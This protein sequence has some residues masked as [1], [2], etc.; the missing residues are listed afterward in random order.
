LQPNSQVA[1]DVRGRLITDLNT[2]QIVPSRNGASQIV[3]YLT[4]ERYGLG[5]SLDKINL[6]S[7]KAAANYALSNQLFSDGATDPNATFKE[8]LTQLAGAFNGM[9]FESFGQVYCKIDGP[10]VVSFDF[11]EEN[12]SA[13]SVS[14]NSGGSG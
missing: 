2:G 9:I 4:N 5:V 1:V 10:D 13:G 14:L 7:F 11:D 6:D 3:D 8:N 12:I